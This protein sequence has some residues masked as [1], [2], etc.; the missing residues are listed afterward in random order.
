LPQPCPKCGAKFIVQ[1]VTKA[2]NRIRCVS[3]GCD[4]TADDEPPEPSQA[5]TGTS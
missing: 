5:A 2:G 3:E 1:K 4:Y